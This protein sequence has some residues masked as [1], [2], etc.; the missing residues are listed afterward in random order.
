M[1]SDTNLRRL[2]IRLA[3]PSDLG[4]APAGRVYYQRD[5][6]GSIRKA[7]DTRSAH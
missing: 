3:I 7:L 4:R 5:S 1:C 6:I 2:K